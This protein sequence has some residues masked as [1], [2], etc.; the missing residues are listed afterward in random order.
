M[1]RHQG[2]QELLPFLLLPSPS[3]F[4]FSLP[5]L[6]FLPTC[7]VA[8][9]EESH[10][11]SRTSK[12]KLLNL[13]K[14][15][16]SQQV[17]ETYKTS[18]PSPPRL[19]EPP[20]GLLKG[21]ALQSAELPPSQAEITGRW[22]SWR[23]LVV[24]QLPWSPPCSCEQPFTH[25]RLNTLASQIGRWRHHYSDLMSVPYLGVGT[26]FSGLSRISVK[27][28]PSPF[29]L[30]PLLSFPPFSSVPLLSYPFPSP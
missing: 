28:F 3:A 27:L 6:P 20:P 19:Y 5:A 8:I 16:Q 9:L 24:L 13:G 25:A 1:I 11:D 30:L 2:L 7:P 14:L 23:A 4:H 12:R 15:T 18:T 10:Q 17:P 26:H 21:R 22:L 29:P